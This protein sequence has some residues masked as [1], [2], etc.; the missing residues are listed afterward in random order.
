M[1][2]EMAIIP[3][4]VRVN[5][6]CVVGI[7]RRHVTDG[8]LVGCR[9]SV[10]SPAQTHQGQGGKDDNADCVSRS[11]HMQTPLAFL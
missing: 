2:I 8:D 10:S 3:I 6:M 5:G 11:I 4:V 7:T 9:S 1:M